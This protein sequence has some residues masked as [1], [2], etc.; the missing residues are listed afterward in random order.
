MMLVRVNA[1]SY[2]V[3]SPRAAPAGDWVFC[4]EF[5]CRGGT[6]VFGEGE[7]A[8]YVYQIIKGAMRTYKL[9]SDGRRQ[10]NSFHLT[11]EMFGFGSTHRFTAEA[12]VETKVRIYYGFNF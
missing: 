7:E 9:L 6:E 12:I 5:N 11:G 4:S 2:P 8:E 1:V 10:I 3:E